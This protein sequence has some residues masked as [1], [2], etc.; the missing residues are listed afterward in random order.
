MRRLV[1]LARRPA[2]D[3]LVLIAAVALPCRYLAALDS[4]YYID[5]SNHQ[6]AIS[7][8]AAFFRHHGTMPGTFHT[9]EIAG[10]AVPVFYGSLFTPVMGALARVTSPE[11]AIRIAVVALSAAQ[12][13]LVSTALGRVGAPRSV[14]LGVAC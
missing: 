11:L 6:W 8:T 7:Y 14:A 1:E 4:D 13:R 3:W 10:L 9:A 5:W 12:F 2:L